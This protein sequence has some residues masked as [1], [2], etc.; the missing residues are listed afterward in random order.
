[1][2]GDILNQYCHKNCDLNLCKNYANWICKQRHC[3]DQPLHGVRQSCDHPCPRTR[4]VATI[5]PTG[6]ILLLHTVF[7]DHEAVGKRTQNC[8]QYLSRQEGTRNEEPRRTAS[9]A[10]LP[11]HKE[12]TQ[13]AETV[14][15][16]LQMQM[17]LAVA[18]IRTPSSSTTQ[19]IYDLCVHPKIIPKLRTQ[20]QETLE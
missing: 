4:K 18:S 6:C 16:Q 10:W 15:I 7:W 5:P 19:G 8:S 17:T 14:N 9:N 3:M 1:M 2:E 12:K 20:V 13:F 11:H